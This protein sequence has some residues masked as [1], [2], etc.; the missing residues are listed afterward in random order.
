MSEGSST[1]PIY[2]FVHVPKCAGSTFKEHFMEHMLDRFQRAPG[3]NNALRIVDS[4]FTDMQALEPELGSLDVIGG[5]SISK[6]IRR[7][8]GSRPFHEIILIRD[9]LSFIVSLYNF[10]NKKASL[11]SLGPVS[12]DLFYRSLPRNPVSRFILNRYLEIG[13]PKLLTYSSFD[14]LQLID[15]AFRQFWFVG[16]HKYCDE[17]IAHMSERFGIP[18]DLQ[19]R[20]V[21]P[22]GCLKPEDVDPG[23]RD[24]IMEE[25]ILDQA[26]F[27]MWGDARF[28]GKQNV[29]TPIVPA[30]DH[31]AHISREVLRNFTYPVIRIERR[32]RAPECKQ[33]A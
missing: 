31:V 26:L 4:K 21:S 16:S 14:R 29:S 3:R 32:L 19:D 9:P 7:L 1:R 5:H 17:L 6:S 20:N 8:A 33:A 24:R 28:S 2:F 12:L 15:S 22:E 10:R 11:Q 30:N 13:Y 27:D 18:S 25:N 23:L